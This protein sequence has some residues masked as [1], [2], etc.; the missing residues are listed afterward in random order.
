[1]EVFGCPLTSNHKRGYFWGYL[2]NSYP[3]KGTPTMK[4]TA[5]KVRNAKPESKPYK[6]FDGKGLFLLVKPNGGRYWRMKYR[7]HGKE[8]TLALGVYP[9]VSL[10]Q[11]RAA[12]TSA[13]QRLAAENVDPMAAK[14]SGKLAAKE[15]AQTS[16]E[17]I[18]REWAE[19]NDMWT[20]DHYNRVIQS[21]EKDVFARLG[22]Q[23][24]SEI[25]T[26]TLLAV[27]R[28]IESRDAL[29]TA[30]RV[31]QRCGAVF[32][33]AIQTGRATANPA[34]ELKGVLKT[35]KVQHMASVPRA[36]LPALIEAIDGYD[37]NPV[38]RLGLKL[39]LYTFV[40][41]GELRG[42]RWDEFDMDA[43]EWR[44][45]AERMK[46]GEPHIVPLSRQALAVLDELRPI[47]GVA[48]LAFH[49]ERSRLK[50]MSENTLLYALYRLGYKGRATPHGF[51]ATASSILNEQGYNPDAI[52]RQLSH[53]ERNTVRSAYNHHARYMKERRE[54]MRWWG[55]YLDSLNSNVVPLRK[56]RQ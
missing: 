52:E 12:T 47:T 42:A 56:K 34:T 33:Y 50:P 25:D 21:L 43:K 24:I 55:D 46:M 38:T 16:F 8:K 37:G 39:L 23:P 36:E 51:R 2:D 15:K 30:S 48:E 26:P 7:Y 17:R 19:T 53:T 35:R 29:E 40:R 9:D 28:R 13:K 3:Q 6:L 41:P 54:I 5:V 11:A 49:G 45:P 22:D 1:M 18:A 27:I 20:D 10:E 14:K 4:L 44:I 32:R 31:L